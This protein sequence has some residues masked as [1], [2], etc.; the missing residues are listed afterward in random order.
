M[1]VRYQH[2]TALVDHERS[3]QTVQVRHKRNCYCFQEIETLGALSDVQHVL[4][5]FQVYR[6]DSS[7]GNQRSGRQRACVYGCASVIARRNG[8]DEDLGRGVSSEK[9]AGCGHANR[10][11]LPGKGDRARLPGGKRPVLAAYRCGLL[12]G[13]A[14]LPIRELSDHDQT[15][16]AAAPALRPC[17]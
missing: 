2:L 14:T 13:D 1:A 5:D 7:V 17:L 8:N 11:R 9:A 16:P 15:S 12:S 4:S 10:G 3:A 6:N